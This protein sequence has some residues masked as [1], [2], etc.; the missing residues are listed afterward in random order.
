MNNKDEIF[1]PEISNNNEIAMSDEVN[2]K[3]DELLHYGVKGQKHGRR[4]YQN[5]D[6]SLTPEGRI[7]Y[8]YDDDD[9]TFDEEGNSKDSEDAKKVRQIRAKSS[10][11]RSNKDIQTANERQRLQNENIQL[12]K[13]Y[14]DLTK[15]SSK[16]E[17]FKAGLKDAAEI[18]N[19]INNTVKNAKS[20]IKE[21]F[22]AFKDVK[23]LISKS[24]LAVLKGESG[25][26]TP[27][28]DPKTSSDEPKD[29]PKSKK[30]LKAETKAAKIEKKSILR[31]IKW[32]TDAMI[33]GDMIS[34]D[35]GPITKK[36]YKKKKRR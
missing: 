7:R 18:T 33:E 17:K 10:A 8:G 24:P 30:E 5:Y 36:E 27:K 28:D 20:F 25:G 11:E 14:E 6:G 12:Q 29:S 35:M 16:Y 31:N 21:T 1:I 13:T 22:G 3:I 19:N 2:E 4:R 26:K 15:Q 32:R 9:E 34:P 23:S